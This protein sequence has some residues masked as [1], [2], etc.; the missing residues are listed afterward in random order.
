M[1]KLK[2]TAKELR[3][4]G[5]PE[6]PVI[7]VA[8]QVMEK[9]FKYYAKEEAIRVIKKGPNWKPAVQNGR[10]VNY[11]HIQNIIFVVAESE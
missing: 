1:N 7:P 8:M 6:S 2:I 4:M 11:R 10:N 5:Y 9:H 3:A